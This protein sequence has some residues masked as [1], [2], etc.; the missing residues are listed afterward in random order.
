MSADRLS[1]DR[2]E[3]LLNLSVIGFTTGTE[4]RLDLQVRKEAV[5]DYKGYYVPA[6][7]H[8]GI[9]GREHPTYGLTV[10]DEEIDARVVVSS[11]ARSPWLETG[12]PSL[13]SIEQHW[14]PVDDQNSLDEMLR[15]FALVEE[16]ALNHHYPHLS[17]S[18]KLSV[19]KEPHVNVDALRE[20]GEMLSGFDTAADNYIE[21]HLIF[22][23]R[24]PRGFLTKGGRWKKM[25]L[26]DCREFSWHDA[27]YD[28]KG[29]FARHNLIAEMDWKATAA[30]VAYQINLIVESRGLN[31]GD[32]SLPNDEETNLTGRHLNEAAKKLSHSDIAIIIFDDDSDSHIFTLMPK[33][34]VDRF[35]ACGHEIGLTLQ[36]LPP[37]RNKIS[38]LLTGWL[39]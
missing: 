15:L 16:Y 17:R 12:H 18:E 34:R 19:V 2:V 35:L 23:A 3:R 39:S 25:T 1:R 10:L 37:P 31:I 7:V 6:A 11:A 24:D 5:P 20:F 28:E 30:D 9:A 33:S 27:I 26:S 36:S 21:K 4:P 8:F 13:A 32:I 29:Y 22:P 14:K 38:K